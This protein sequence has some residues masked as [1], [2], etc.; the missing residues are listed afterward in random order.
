MTLKDP[1]DPQTAG[2]SGYGNPPQRTRFRKGESG[3]PRGRPKGRH[4]GAPYEAV[5]GQLVTVREAGAERRITAAEAFLL[6]LTK[7]GLEG[8]GAAARAAIRSIEEVRDKR[9]VDKPGELTVCWRLVD[10]GS[11]NTA[12]LPLRMAQLLDQYRDTA[13]ILLEPWLVE[14]AL[15]RLGERRLSTEEQQIVLRATRL[16]HKVRWPQWWTKLPGSF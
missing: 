1:V 8:D 16:P 7:R 3:N 12:L 9:I 11:V 13:R 2:K 6:H 15:A 10:P 4:R 14:A 5:L